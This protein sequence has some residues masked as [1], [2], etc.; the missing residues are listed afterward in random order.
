MGDAD[1]DA[2]TS[3]AVV[4]QTSALKSDGPVAETLF[5]RKQ[6]SVAG[7]NPL[8]W[9]AVSFTCGAGE[10]DDQPVRI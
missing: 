1:G 7:V 6:Y 3:S 2:T 5:I 9:T 8:S 10:I 4:A